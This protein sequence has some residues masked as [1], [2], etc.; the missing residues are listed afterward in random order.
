[1]IFPLLDDQNLRCPA[2]RIEHAPE[3]KKALK[4]GP[5]YFLI[6]YAIVHYVACRR[7]RKALTLY[8]AKKQYPS[9]KSALLYIYV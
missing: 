2:E 3:Q 4:G 7:T 5:F 8:S 1:M 6:L 9:R